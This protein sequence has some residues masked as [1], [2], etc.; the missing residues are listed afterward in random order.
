MSVLAV[1]FAGI[2]QIFARIFNVCNYLIYWCLWQIRRKN[3][4][5]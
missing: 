2:G 1:N 3:M 5:F 4:L